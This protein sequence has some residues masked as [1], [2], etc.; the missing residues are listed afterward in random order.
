VTRRS[1]CL[2]VALAAVLIGV[3]AW[4]VAVK[5]CRFGDR[6]AHVCVADSDGPPKNGATKLEWAPIFGYCVGGRAARR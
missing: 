4:T 1:R 3:L 6:R 5:A 2:I